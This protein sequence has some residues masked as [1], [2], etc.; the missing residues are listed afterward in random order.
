MANND[1][2]SGI[3]QKD[4]K[5]FG[6]DF[7]QL[8]RVAS[9]I[10]RYYVKWE[11]DIVKYLPKLDKFINLFNKKYGN[12]K[13]KV[14]KRIDGVDVRILLNEGT[15]KDIFNNCASRIAGL[16]S[17]GTINFGSA[18]VAEMEKFA[19]EIDKI[20]DK[21]Y[22][23]YYQPE[24][25][26]YSVFLSKN[27]SEK[28]VE[29]HWEI[30]ESINEVSPDFRICAYYA[31]KDGYSKKIRLLDEGATFGFL[32]L[33]SEKEKREWFDRLNPRGLE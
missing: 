12:I 13:V 16:K 19:N 6:R 33:L 26:I 7:S 27:K 15:V 9:E 17:I 32:S 2:L 31:L 22:L 25:G 5:E 21:L 29:L 3:S 4:M 11:Q 28:M 18:D 1:I 23:T 20:K 24:V 14:L 30:K 10:D 8:L